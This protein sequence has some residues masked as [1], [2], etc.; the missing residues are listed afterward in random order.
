M[1]APTTVRCTSSHPLLDGPRP[2]PKHGEP[3]RLDLPLPDRRYNAYRHGS[4]E[5]AERQFGAANLDL[6]L[7]RV[8]EISGGEAM[9]VNGRRRRL[10]IM[11][12]SVAVIALSSAVATTYSSERAD[13]LQQELRTNVESSFADT[14]LETVR[15]LNASTSPGRPDSGPDAL[16]RFLERPG[17]APDFFQV[18]PG[19]S[20]S[21]LA[22]YSV[23]YWGQDRCVL[24]TWEPSGT[25]FSEAEEDNCPVYPI[26]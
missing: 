11:I 21:Y 15:D 8:G 20:E 6:V 2:G 18:N 3:E 1:Q 5:G 13:V 25:S 9:S 16:G 26:R 7:L 14:D 19:G 22:V 17:Q 24:A 10:G 23:E 12:A 4:L